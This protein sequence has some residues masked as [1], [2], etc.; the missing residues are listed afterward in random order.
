MKFR[1]IFYTLLLAFT[2]L[3]A[4]ARPA[5]SLSGGSVSSEKASSGGG[6]GL[7]TDGQ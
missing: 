7:G 2:S 3:Y 4:Q 6:Q 1:N 5:V